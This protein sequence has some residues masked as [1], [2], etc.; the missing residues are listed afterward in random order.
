MK[1]IINLL[2]VNYRLC[3]L[4]INNRFNTLK[5][6]FIHDYQYILVFSQILII[7]ILLIYYKNSKENPYSIHFK[8]KNEYKNL[9]WIPDWVRQVLTDEKVYNVYQV[10]SYFYNVLKYYKC[11]LELKIMLFIYNHYSLAIFIKYILFTIFLVLC[12]YLL[13]KLVSYCYSRFNGEVILNKYLNVLDSKFANL[14][15]WY[16]KIKDRFKF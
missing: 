2:I 8:F 15:S 12:S 9:K 16:Y 14:K 10:I 3:V 1:K 13:T 5:T 7:Y 11:I 4:S 6:L